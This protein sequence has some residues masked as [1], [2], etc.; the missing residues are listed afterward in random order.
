MKRVKVR[1][2]AA[3]VVLAVVFS[4]VPGMAIAAEM[5][6]SNEEIAYLDAEINL[7]NYISKTVTYAT[8]PVLFNDMILQSNTSGA[9]LT[10][11]VKSNKFTNFLGIILAVHYGTI[12]WTS[13]GM[14]LFDQ[15]R[16]TFN[17]W[18]TF[19]PHFVSDESASWTWFDPGF[20]G[21]GKS[22]LRLVFTFGVPTPWGPIG[23]SHTSRITTI[24]F[25]DGS[26]D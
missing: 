8:T 6:S 9:W 12:A 21:T 11:V 26:F 25:S 18:W 2:L 16:Y 7:E 23:S 14:F 1:A 17:D 13:D 20:G 24:V 10:R 15:P 5:R 22:N 4:V 3:L 19:P